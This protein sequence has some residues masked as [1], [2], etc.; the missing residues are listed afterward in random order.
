MKL[1]IVSTLYKSAATVEGFVERATQAA[2]A[3]TDDFELIL[4]DDGSPDDA[5]EIAIGLLDRYPALKIVELSRNFGHHKALMTGLDHSVGDYVFLIDSDLEEA[6]ELLTEFWAELEARRADVIYGYQA[7]RNGGWTGRAAGGIAYWAFSQLIPHGIPQNHLTVRLMRRAYVDSLV[8]HREREVVIGGLWVITGYRQVGL[9][10]EKRIKQGTSYSLKRRWRLL[11]D[12][13][14]SFSEAP[15]VAIFY[16]GM[17][18]SAV[19]GVVGMV[20]LIRF[21]IGGVGVDGWVSVMLSVWFLGGLAIF[22]IGI[23]G[24]Y[25]S[26]IFIETKNRPYTIVRA[27]HEAAGGQA[28]S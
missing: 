9:P 20:I 25:L 18:I 21:L 26:K 12:S 15:L 14:T 4:V 1:S 23:I 24:L 2:N 7:S 28:R 13:I 17:L 5:L 22:F 27:V 11:L 10:V 3:I 6:P 19:A 8:A 16:V